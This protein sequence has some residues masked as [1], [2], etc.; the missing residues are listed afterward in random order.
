[1]AVLLHV[2]G[3]GIWSVKCTLGSFNAKIHSGWREFAA[4][5]ELKIGDVCIFEVIKGTPL[6]I[7]VTI[8]PAAGCTPMQKI[9]GEVP[10]VSASKNKIIGTDNSV[11]PKVVQTK[12]LKKLRGVSYGSNSKIKEEH[13]EGTGIEHSVERLGNCQGSKRKRLEG[14]AE[15]DVSIDRTIK[16]EKLQQ[17]VALSSFTRMT[18]KRGE[19]CRMHKQQDKI[20]NDKNKIVMDKERSIAYQRAN[21]FKSKN[22]FIICLMQPSYISR[23]YNLVG[24]KLDR[25]SNNLIL[26]QSMPLYSIY[27]VH[28]FWQSIRFTFARKYLRENYNNLVLRVPGRGSWS[29]KCHLRTYRAE[30]LDGWKAFVLENKLKLGDV[31][32]L[33]VIRGTPLFIDV[34]IFREAGSMPSQ[35]IDGEVPE[36]SASKNKIIKTENSVQ[37]SQPEIVHSKKLNLEKQKKADSYDF[38]S[39]I[40]EE[41][42][43]GSGSVRNNLR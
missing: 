42:G 15:T 32:V 4:D 17:D 41:Y 25:L 29:V 24:N 26:I 3:R 13:G 21:A 30:I 8:F 11:Q 43:E 14:E 35:K 19:S 2:P 33:E 34:T 18:T 9:A 1:M 7:D 28:L 20:V 12:K 36:V 10:G 16:V 37:C 22:P 40:I 27:Y 5:N 31:C 38:T 23:S 39:K 6:L